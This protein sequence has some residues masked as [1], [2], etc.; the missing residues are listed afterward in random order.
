MLRKMPG[1][2][3]VAWALCAVCGAT[4]RPPAASAAVSLH[5]NQ[6]AY[7]ARG[8]KV[9][10]IESET[11]FTGS[12]TASLIDDMT[13]TDVVSA[14]LSTVLTNDEWAPGKHFYA[15]DFSAFQ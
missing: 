13:S 11:P 8:P 6:V 9:A 14:G 12:E 7:D 10:L 15:A 5:T 4:L 3:A 1:L 2:S